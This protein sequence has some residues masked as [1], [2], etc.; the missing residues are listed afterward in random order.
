[1]VGFVGTGQGRDGLGS[2]AVGQG[3]VVGP[4]QGG[5][6]EGLS[7][8]G[9]EG[10][11]RRGAGRRGLSGRCVSVWIGVDRGGQSGQEGAAWYGLGS[12]AGP[13]LG[14]EDLGWVVVSY[15]LPVSDAS[16][17]SY[18]SSLNTSPVHRAPQRFA[19]AR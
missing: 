13:G 10:L 8:R 17:A 16:S 12:Q 5:V 3:W 9:R 14:G 11:A 7:G 2:R 6:G 4:G 18:S 15:R 19:T 1:M